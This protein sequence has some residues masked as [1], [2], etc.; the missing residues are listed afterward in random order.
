[1]TEDFGEETGDDTNENK[2]EEEETRDK[3]DIKPRK[4]MWREPNPTSTVT[5]NSEFFSTAS[6]RPAVGR[7]L[8]RRLGRRSGPFGPAAH[9]PLRDP[10]AF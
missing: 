6:S 10:L 5:Q 2:N 7:Q 8:R 3:S 4:E 1:M 9:G